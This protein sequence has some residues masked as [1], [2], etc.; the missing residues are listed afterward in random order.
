MRLSWL[1]A[2]LALCLA[3]DENELDCTLTQ[4]GGPA[5]PG[6]KCAFPF[7]LFEETFDMCTTGIT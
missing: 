3:E 5:G 7:V 6:V 4:Y 1:W 2:L